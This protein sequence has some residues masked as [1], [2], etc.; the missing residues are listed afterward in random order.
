MDDGDGGGGDETEDELAAAAAGE[1]SR[2]SGNVKR[3]KRVRRDWEPT[4]PATVHP[5]NDYLPTD[6]AV[7]FAKAVLECPEPVTQLRKV[8]VVGNA[9]VASGMFWPRARLS[10]PWW[11][12]QIGCEKPWPLR[13]MINNSLIHLG[14][15]THATKEGAVRVVRPHMNIAHSSSLACRIAELLVLV[16]K[17]DKAYAAIM[18]HISKFNAKV[19]PPIALRASQRPSLSGLSWLRAAQ[20]IAPTP[21]AFALQQSDPRRSGE[22]FSGGS[23]RPVGWVAN[24]S[25]PPHTTCGWRRRIFPPHFLLTTPLHLHGRLAPQQAQRHLR[26]LPRRR[27]LPHSAPHSSA[28]AGCRAWR[29]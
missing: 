6:A 12:R 29:V 10:L 4:A 28:V 17:C 23:S 14:D 15:P 5:P 1:R 26:R 18:G 24:G 21:S 27:L 19:L 11:P 7:S 2:P 9:V 25:Q 20:R 13:V 16:D 22:L 3:V 8:A